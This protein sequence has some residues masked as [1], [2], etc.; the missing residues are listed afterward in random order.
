MEECEFRMGTESQGSIHGDTDMRLFA[1]KDVWR[2]HIFRNLL[3]PAEF[4][5]Y[6]DKLKEEICA[7][8]PIESDPGNITR[9][10]KSGWSPSR[11]PG[12][13][14][15]YNILIKSA[16]YLSLPVEFLMARMHGCKPPADC[17]LRVLRIVSM[18]TQGGVAKVCLQSI[19]AMPAEAVRY[20]LLVF[21][22]NPRTPELDQHPHIR[23]TYKE[24]QLWPGSYHFKLFW[25]V[26]CVAR[27]I[28]QSRAHLIHLHEPQFTPVVRMAAMFAGGVP[29]CVQLHSDYTSRRNSIRDEVIEMTRHSL[30]KCRLIACSETI[31]RA[32]EAWLSPI[33]HPIALVQDGADDN[34][35]GK[36][37]DTLDQD[38]CC[39]AGDRVVVA[40][41]S[42]LIPL[43]SVLRISCRVAGNYSMRAMRSI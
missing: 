14:W 7:G 42:H 41:M 29:V 25:H 26:F 9:R 15:I 12:H 31:R 5:A 39:A 10:T 3:N 27:I 32:G 2:E 24:L 40:M 38:L 22:K 4:A 19:L 30:R 35:Y 23:L 28:R 11:F 21:D 34:V 17:P 33:R 36:F 1:G 8:N 43:K 18:I 37:G 16:Y 6:E 13:L 20:H